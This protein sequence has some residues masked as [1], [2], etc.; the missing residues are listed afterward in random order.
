MGPA[1]LAV[2]VTVLIPAAGSGRRLG[3]RTPKQFLPLGGIPML[4]RTLLIFEHEP[5]VDEVVVAAAPDQVE[6]TWDL[7]R[8]HGCHKVTRVV[9]GGEERQDSVRRALA[10]VASRPRIVAVHDAARPLLPSDRLR[11]ILLAAAEQQALVMAVPVTDTVKRAAASGGGLPVVTETLPRAE[12]W[13]AQTPQVFSAHLL[14]RAL[15]Q[16]NLDGFRGTDDAAVV[17]RLGVQVAIF[18]GA[19]DNIKVTRPE[20]FTA[21]EALLA[22][23]STAD[24]PEG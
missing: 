3:G 21:A 17:E 24:S 19:P 1:Q 22:A 11:G 20:D 8:R 14:S 6:A 10:A 4:A 2:G 7:V 5:L 15:E 16:A 9:E 23:R 18:P 13:A 12:L